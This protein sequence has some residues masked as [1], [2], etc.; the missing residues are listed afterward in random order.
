MKRVSIGTLWLDCGRQVRFSYL[1][2]AQFIQSILNFMFPAYHAFARMPCQAQYGLPSSAFSLVCRCM[3]TADVL[4]GF[5]LQVL[6]ANAYFDSDWPCC[7][8]MH[9]HAQIGKRLC[10]EEGS[11]LATFRS[12]RAAETA[13]AS[14][15]VMVAGLTSRAACRNNI[16]GRSG[17]LDQRSTK[18]PGHTVQRPYQRVCL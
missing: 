13:T 17:A 16:I 15:C 8:A 3:M 9:V 1:H 4:R 2:A 6:L 14:S 10:I 18:L 11:L 5:A 7:F 12:T